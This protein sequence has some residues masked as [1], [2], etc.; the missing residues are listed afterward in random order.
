[1][2]KMKKRESKDNLKPEIGLLDSI[3]TKLIFIMVSLIVVSL[4][5][6]VSIS[7]VTSTTKAKNDALELLDSNANFVESK[8]ADIIDKNVIALESFATAPSTV[9]YINSY[10][11]EDAA[12]PDDV[13]LAQMDAINTNID[14][15]NTSCILSMVTGDQVLRTDRGET[16]NV[17]DRDYFKKCVSTKDVTVSDILTDKEDDERLAII[18]VPVFDDKTGEMIGTIQRSINLNVL[19]DFL[20]ENVS[21]GFIA[22]SQGIVA[23]H[24]KHEIHATDEPEDLSY[25]QFMSSTDTAGYYKTNSKGYLEYISWIREPVT[26]Y[27]VAV[28]KTQSEIM[29]PAVRS[30]VTVV[31]IGLILML[32]AMVL[33][34]IFSKSFTEPI[35]AVARSLIA[36]SDGRFVLVEK[37]AAR[38]DEFGAIA[39]ATNTLISKLESIVANIKSSSEE[40]N[41]SSEELSQMA[42]QISQTAD[43][44]SNAIQDVSAGATQQ[45][46]EIQDANQSV[47]DIGKAVEEVKSSATEL[48]ETTDRMKEASEISGESL[49]SLRDS[50][51]EM[52]EK[53]NEISRTIQ[54]TQNA[55]DNISEKVEGITSIATQTNLLSL[56][57]SIEA[58]RAGEAGKGFAVVAEEIG[59]LAEDSRQMAGDIRKEMDALLEQSNAAVLAAEDVKKGN[60]D[61]QVALEETLKSVNGMLSDIESTVGGVENISRGADTCERSKDTVVDTMSALSAISEENAASSEQT[62]SSME[63]LS[64]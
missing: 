33:S 14:D 8:F 46:E 34:F 38:K 31:I 32:I 18:I 59:K 54:A 30:A 51:A 44:V 61:Q 3:K 25:A 57:A 55:V 15:G 6:A 40:V 42:D 16:K 7:Y 48:S 29:G 37:H 41:S 11:T 53:I 63:E 13:M 9:T 36:L 52:T 47:A 1:M 50:S 2:G 45:A 58:A 21:D 28:L 26:G 12:I 4:A 23:A 17:A 5:I 27:T 20:S 56:N 22:D 49:V 24:A 39:N 64:A 62:G 35:E 19:H 60:D 10:G 43:G